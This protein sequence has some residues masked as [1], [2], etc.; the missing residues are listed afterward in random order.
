MIEG[1]TSS[2]PSLPRNEKPIMEV[3]LTFGSLGDI[4]A[5]C[6]IVIELSRALGSTAGSAR[7]Y[8]DIREDLDSF[9]RVLMQVTATYEQYEVS[10]WL[11]GVDKEI[12]R[13]VAECARLVQDALDRIRAK[14]YPP[15]LRSGGS[16]N[17][18]RDAIKKLEWSFRNEKESLRTLQE[19]LRSRTETITLLT[20]IAAQRSARVDNLTMMDR[21]NEVKVLMDGHQHE[22]L[23]L[24]QEHINVSREQKDQL[25]KIDGKLATQEQTSWSMLALMKNVS[26]AVI[27]LKDM[28]GTCAQVAVSLQTLA[29]N[30]MFFRGLDPTRNMPVFFEDALGNVLEISVDWIHDWDMFH[31]L[32]EH[33]F[34]NLKGHQLVQQQ[35]YALEENCTGKNIDRRRPWSASV[36]RGMKVNM[37]MVFT[38]VPDGEER[39]PGCK[40]GADFPENGAIQCSNAQ[41]GMWLRTLR[42]NAHPEENRERHF[43]DDDNFKETKQIDSVSRIDEPSDF[44]RVCLIVTEAVFVPPVFTPIPP[45]QRRTL[46]KPLA[47]MSDLDNHSQTHMCTKCSKLFDR[48]C[49]LNKHLNYHEGPFKCI[50]SGC[51]YK[52]Q[53]F[54][55]AKD[56]LRHAHSRHPNMHPKWTFFCLFPPCPYKSTLESNWKQ[57]MENVHNWIYIRTESSGKRK[58]QSMALHGQAIQT[59][60]GDPMETPVKTGV[61]SSEIL[62][63]HIG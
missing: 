39:C 57:H 13:A 29:S 48:R 11:E 9:V 54:P 58:G 4:I 38:D 60:V 56:L 28:V 59:V 53:G 18:A 31:S 50:F 37:S 16:G 49:D 14:K 61:N 20:G 7:E 51:I 10:P 3:A 12:K 33:R 22:L 2:A 1:F 36:R 47:P 23:R 62:S 5:I 6:Q 34:Q 45:K 63:K 24:Y 40:T 30:P 26:V 35:A 46:P 32:L 27:E 15:S 21:I 19:R 44:R 41:C 8:Q 17:A 43:K 42:K 55:S 25:C 52:K